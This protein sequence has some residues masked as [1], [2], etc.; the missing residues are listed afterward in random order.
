[1]PPC[2]KRVDIKKSL[3]QKVFSRGGVAQLGERLNGIQ[4]AVSS[5]LSTSTSIYKHLWQSVVSAFFM[6]LP[7]V[8]VLCQFFCYG[9]VSKKGEK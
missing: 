6:R 5:I 3:R 8:P 9:E 1:M 7:F 4:E 2:A